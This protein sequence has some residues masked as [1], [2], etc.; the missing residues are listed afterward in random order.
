MRAIKIA[1]VQQGRGAPSIDRVHDG[2][3]L[4]KV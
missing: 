2:L 3:G 4:Q 1:P